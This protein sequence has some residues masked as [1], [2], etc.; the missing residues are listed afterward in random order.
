MAIWD[1]IFLTN[2]GTMT[3]QCHFSHTLSKKS[4]SALLRECDINGRA[5]VQ[6]FDCLSHFSFLNGT[7][8]GHLV[9]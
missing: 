3:L 2:I 6:Q 9:I 4:V 7:T 8:D 1:P 5:L